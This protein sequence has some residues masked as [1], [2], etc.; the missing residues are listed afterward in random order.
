[1]LCCAKRCNRQGYGRQFILRLGNR[2]YRPGGRVCGRTLSGGAFNT[3]VAFGVSIMG[4][5]SWSN[6]W[7]YIVAQAAGA[8]VAAFVFKRAHPGE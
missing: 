1:M 6:I 2:L 4:L 7:V 5:F 8:A 3:A